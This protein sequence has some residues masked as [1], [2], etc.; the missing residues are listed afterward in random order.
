MRAALRRIL[1]L[2][3]CQS[4]NFALPARTRLSVSS[5]AVACQL[6]ESI[7]LSSFVRSAQRVSIARS[8]SSR[9]MRLIGK[10]IAML[11][12]CPIAESPARTNEGSAGNQPGL[13]LNCGYLG[14]FALVYLLQ[15]K[16]PAAER[17][18]LPRFLSTQDP[19]TPKAFGV[20]YNPNFLRN[21]GTCNKPRC[22]PQ[23]ARN[24]GKSARPAENAPRNR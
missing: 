2:A 17:P 20:N 11:Q 18:A 23:H 19:L 15:T 5:S 21:S 6:G 16:T 7:S 4:E 9:D 3:T 1:L 12:I 13:T 22:E 24:S 10:V 14:N 8:L